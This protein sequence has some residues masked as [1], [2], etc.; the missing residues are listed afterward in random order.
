MSHEAIRSLVSRDDD[1]VLNELR[2]LAAS[3]DAF[4]R[5]TAIEIIGQH[6][7]GPELRTI[8]VAAF[9]DPSD[10]VRRTACGIVEHWK[11]AEA[12]DL[13]LPFLRAPEASTRECALRALANIWHEADFH[14]IFN[15]YRRDPEIG[16]RKEAA[17][18]LR[19]G[20]AASNWRLLFDAFSRDELP[21]HRLWACEIAE[22]FGDPDVL[23]AL[24]PLLNDGD[25]H[26]RKS[27]AHA[28][29]AIGARS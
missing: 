8:V 15:L 2:T 4:V 22:T 9:S 27:A 12:H 16:V 23:P 24:T 14:S 19:R 7:R 26:V 13:V 5:R 11:L 20:A 29:Q 17:W 18:T 10:Y 21:R 28:H 25:G 3:S 1:E 6:K